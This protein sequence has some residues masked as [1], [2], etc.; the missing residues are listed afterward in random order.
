MIMYITFVVVCI[1]VFVDVYDLKCPRKIIYFSI[2][3]GL[4]LISALRYRLGID[5]IRYEE[6]YSDIPTIFDLRFDDFLLIPYEPLWI[7]FCSLL[8]SF[9]DSFFF[10]QLVHGIIINWIFCSFLYKHVDAPYIA[11]FFYT[12]AM[13][14]LF[15]FE[16]IRESLA[17]AI[18]L[19]FWKKS[20]NRP[21]LY[22]IMC[23]VCFMIHYGAVVLFLVPCVKKMKLYLSTLLTI[24]VS[25]A[26]IGI[27][28][29]EF[30][31]Q[32]NFSFISPL[33][34]YRFKTYTSREGSFSLYTILIYFLIPFTAFILW[35]LFVKRQCT[36]PHFVLLYFIMLL[37]S[38]FVPI[39]LRCANY[40]LIF[41]IIFLTDLS[42]ML[43][44]MHA[45]TMLRSVWGVLII[46]AFSFP[47]L[48]WF[49]VGIT[50][51]SYKNYD[52][53]FPYTN[54]ISKEISEKRELIKDVEF[55]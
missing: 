44:R 23:F 11:L 13:Y 48:S 14:F 30:L 21:Y 35:I 25:I 54:V 15:N 27:F 28:L 5:S 52:R 4:I 36:F 45:K 10:L 19:M 9:N 34:D 12:V 7:I 37:G 39:S 31:L 38:F 51:V 33:I 55:L 3:F 43:I 20:Q 46:L 53:Y 50:N 29:H 8:R 6:S 49:F 24:I 18:F 16:S 32:L 41:Y 2:V 26:L 47:Y 42:N 40:F 22:Y 17:I 1:F